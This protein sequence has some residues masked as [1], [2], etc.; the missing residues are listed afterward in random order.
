MSFSPSDIQLV[1][2][3]FDGTIITFGAFLG[4]GVFFVG[5]RLYARW[6]SLERKSWGWDDYLILP[7]LLSLIIH[8]S[9]EIGICTHSKIIKND[10]NR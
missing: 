6:T 4:L 3:Y 10:C 5:L 9:A 7:A 8:I 1:K 2:N